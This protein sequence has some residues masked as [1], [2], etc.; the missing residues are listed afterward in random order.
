LIQR[1]KKNRN[2]DPPDGT[3]KYDL[4]AVRKRPTSSVSPSSSVSSC[5][6]GSV[7]PQIDTLCEDVVIG[8]L[9]NES[10]A[11]GTAALSVA[12]SKHPHIDDLPK[13]KKPHAMGMKSGG[14]SIL[15]R[16]QEILPTFEAAGVNSWFR[17]RDSLLLECASQTAALSVAQSN[18][19]PLDDLTKNKKPRAI[20]VKS[21]EQSILQRG[22][23]ILPTFEASGA[24]SW[25]RDASQS[26]VAG[27]PLTA[28]MVPQQRH[29]RKLVQLQQQNQELKPFN[30]ELKTTMTIKQFLDEKGKEERKSQETQL[31]Q[32]RARAARSTEVSDINQAMLAEPNGKEALAEAKLYVSEMEQEVKK[33]IQVKEAL[34]KATTKLTQVKLDNEKLKC[35]LQSL[36]GRFEA[37]QKTLQDLRDDALELHKEI[38]RLRTEKQYLKDNLQRVRTQQKTEEKTS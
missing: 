15:Q 38:E 3:T 30:Q 14:Q 21:G 26:G 19:P 6:N 28:N 17:D 11:A 37:E 8:D 16:G 10:L 7:R 22:Q 27:V 34:E 4:R 32:S 31:N 29:Q 1:R 12:Q 13:N 36:H 5:A 9:G 25:F 23:E 35:E 18:H 2:G 24:N 20:G 33:Y